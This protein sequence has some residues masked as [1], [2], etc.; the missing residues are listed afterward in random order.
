MSPQERILMS[1]PSLFDDLWVAFKSNDKLAFGKIISGLATAKTN[2]RKSIA[3]SILPITDEFS[4]W[5]DNLE[6]ASRKSLGV[7]NKKLKLSI[8]FTEAAFNEM[9][10]NLKKIDSKEK[11]DKPVKQQ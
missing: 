7:M 5:I 3:S 9:N 8:G 11:V 1:F 6:V 2:L 10:A 4:G